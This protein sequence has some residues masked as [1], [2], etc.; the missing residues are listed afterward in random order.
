M[1]PIF[2]GYE[3]MCDAGYFFVI[4]HQLYLKRFEYLIVV[5]CRC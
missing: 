5:T 4:V 3:K 1:D 2:Q